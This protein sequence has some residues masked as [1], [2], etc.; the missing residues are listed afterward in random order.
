MM[1]THTEPSVPD[2]IPPT[3]PKWAE[4]YIDVNGMRTRFFQ[5]G[6][7]PPLLLIPS[8][9]LRAPSYR[10]TIE[11]LAA[12]FQVTAAEMPGSGHSQRLKQPWGFAEGADWAAGL[13]DALNLDRALVVGHSDTGGVAALMG[14][15][16]PDRLDGLVMVDSVGGFP[17][18]TWWS[19]LKSRLHDGMTEESRLNLPLTP[20]MIANLLRHPRNCLYHAFRLAADTEPLE[21]A[22]RITAPTLLAW[23]RRDHTFPPHCA[24]RFQATI[25]DCRI[26]WSNASHDWLI[27][28]PREFADAVASFARELGLIP[29]EIP[30]NNLSALT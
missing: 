22:S 29:P 5:S 26:I 18:A 9:F 30:A 7:G 6:Q 27:L 15:R 12:H 2:L 24:E 10:G 28:H 1:A 3:L 14:V 19:L 16:H 20:H 17:G 4:Q 25:P 13:L 23:G 8:A 21:V 11:G